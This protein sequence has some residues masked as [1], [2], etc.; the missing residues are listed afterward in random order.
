MILGGI[1]F[2]LDA[3]HEELSL[4]QNIDH[5]FFEQG[6]VLQNE[7]DRLFHSIFVNPDR[8]IT[9]V[10]TLNQR[11]GGYTRKE[12]SELTGLSGKTLTDCMRTLIASDFVEQYVPFSEGKRETHYRL[13]DPFCQFY[14][15]F[16]KDMPTK[17]EHFWIH[18][19]A[20][21]PIVS[22]RGLAFE[23]LC[24]CHIRQIKQALGISAVRTNHFAWILRSDE[25]NAQIDLI[26]ERDD[27]VINA[28]EIKFTGDKFIVDKAYYRT[29]Q[30][31]QSLLIEKI[32]R[33]QS[34]QQ[35]LISNYGLKRNEY[36]GIFTQVITLDDLFR[37]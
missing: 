14:L 16:V 28:C 29:L 6:A 24:F 12:I 30:R 2:Y 5:L 34:V 27:R 18:Q 33:K 35:T 32:S 31:R 11:R 9:I 26:I 7:F 19:Q 21:Q 20:S 13:I 8:M 25:G 37:E 22:W 4:A 15:R 3:L 23:N 36:S 1:P 10:T 17:D